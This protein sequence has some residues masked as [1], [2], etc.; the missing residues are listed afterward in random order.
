MAIELCGEGS[1]YIPPCEGGGDCD[2]LSKT[3][4]ENGTYYASDDHVDGY[5]QVEVDVQPDLEM[6][7]VE[8]YGNGLI[9]VEPSPGKDGLSSVEIDVEVE[10]V[11]QQ[12]SVTISANGSTTVTPDSGKDG[13]SSVTIL[14]EVY[15]PLQSDEVTIISNGSR[16]VMPPPGAY[17]L[18]AVIINTAVPNTYSAGDEGKV[19]SGGALVAQ[20]SDSTTANGTFD[21]TLINSF[22]VN[23][24]GGGGGTP[25]YGLINTI[26]ITEAVSLISITLP[27]LVKADG[28]LFLSFESV[29]FSQN[30]YLYLKIGSSTSSRGIYRGS[31]ASA[32]FDSMILFAPSLTVDGKT[33]G[34]FLASYPGWSNSSGGAAPV[35]S[36]MPDTFYLMLGNSS[37][38]FTGGT[39][40]VY[41]RTA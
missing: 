1:V 11:L 20:S 8:I 12:K 33:F 2:L 24:S 5:D 16:T 35:V 41:G 27:D 21:T 3:I 9:V 39:I 38:R 15:P 25:T 14:A 37:R 31:A 32:N 6:Q 13:L 29:T 34:G 30:D 22:T 10:P 17:G 40:K 23:V 19:V 4:T 7:I 26:S 36:T 28:K 18:A